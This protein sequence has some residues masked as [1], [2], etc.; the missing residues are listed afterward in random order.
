MAELGTTR[1]QTLVC[2][3]R[4]DTDIRGANAA[5]LDSLLVLSGVCR[6]QDLALAPPAARPT[7]VATDL[8]G[9]LEPPLSLFVKPSDL[10]PDAF[11]R[12][13][14]ADGNRL[15]QSVVAAAWAA[16][17]EGRPLPDDPATWQTLERQLGLA[18]Q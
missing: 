3:D 14:T 12:P 18:P 11:L 17:D 9:L 10:M 2:G 16:R 15:L 13:S 5:G 8:T 4:L 1:A 6:L 7:Y